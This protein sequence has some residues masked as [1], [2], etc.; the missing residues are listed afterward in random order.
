MHKYQI[1]L[2]SIANYISTFY[3]RVR[4]GKILIPV[5]KLISFLSH[6]DI[7]YY[8]DMYSYIDISRFVNTRYVS[9]HGKFSIKQGFEH[10]RKKV[11]L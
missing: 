11:Q 8:I 6:M 1:F 4:N 3:S 9:V 7:I 5:C 2:V 10:K